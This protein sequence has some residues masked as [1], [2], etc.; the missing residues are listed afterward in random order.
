MNKFKYFAL[1]LL[2]IAVSSC[3]ELTEGNA[4]YSD[5]L[6]IT[7]AL[8]D[9]DIRMA[10]EGETSMGLTIS[11]TDRVT[12]AVTAK[13]VAA[14]EKL[15]AYNAK[16]NASYVLPAAGAVALENA[17]V[18]IN[19]GAY[20]STQAKL[21][22]KDPTLF[23]EGV[24][25][26]LPIE[27][28]SEGKVLE[29]AK[30]VYVVF[31][32][33]ITTKVANI[34]GTYYEIPGF[35]LNEA[36]GHLEQLTMECKVYV[37]AFQ[38]ANPYISS[39]MGL[40]ENFLLRFG[41]VSCDKDQLQLAGGI[42]GGRWDYPNDGG[43]KHPVTYDQHFPTG[44]WFHFACVYDGSEIKMYLDGKAIG[45]P[46]KATGTITLAWG[47]LS[48]AEQSIGP[49]AIGMSAGSRYLNGLVSEFR[50]WDVA[51]NP[52]DLLE[53]ICYVD[54]T[55]PGLIA[56]WRFSGDDLQSDGTVYDLTG[57]GYNARPH[58]TAKWIENHKC[59]Y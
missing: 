2:V 28:E 22:I 55:T 35:R 15:D 18:T 41:D 57:H 30:T 51:R 11:S 42:T 23:K 13:F 3:K 37:N 17:T 26:C 20:M 29:S 36:V 33:I 1:A 46:V 49:F 19:E 44:K 43:T 16:L 4:D 32:P 14:P 6:Y 27:V 25:Y 54:P 10:F 9:T 39:L 8:E 38:S 52:T 56:Y 21:T 47:Y 12:K 53:N 24:R 34:A 59:P 48:S 31:V 58:G 7:G 40:E 45:D 5:V 50:V